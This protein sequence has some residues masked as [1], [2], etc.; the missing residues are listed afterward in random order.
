MISYLIVGKNI[1]W[2]I[3]DLEGA[4][5]GK[6]NFQNLRILAIQSKVARHQLE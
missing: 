4:K 2:K 3:R 6:S 1:L 5:N